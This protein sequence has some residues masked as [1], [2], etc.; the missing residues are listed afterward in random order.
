MIGL[1]KSKKHPGFLIYK[2]GEPIKF[3]VSKRH[4]PNKSSRHDIIAYVKFWPP[5]KIQKLVRLHN[6]LSDFKKNS[7]DAS[8]TK[9]YKEFAKKRIKSLSGQINNLK[10]KTRKEM[11]DARRRSDKRRGR[12]Q[13]VIPAD[14]FAQLNTLL[15]ANKLSEVWKNLKA[16]PNYCP[17]GQLLQEF[18][19]LIQVELQSHLQTIEEM[20]NGLRL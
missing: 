9:A 5:K 17:N 6:K 20:K 10:Q 4:G 2:Q 7:Q 14:E 12:R 3:V 13:R 16:N 15:E 1:P 18:K 8:A 19:E 11:W